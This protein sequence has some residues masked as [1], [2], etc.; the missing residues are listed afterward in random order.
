MEGVG[1]GRRPHCRLSNAS[2][3]LRPNRRDYRRAPCW[4]ARPSTHKPANETQ[5]PI[6]PRPRKCAGAARRRPTAKSRCS[7]GRADWREGHARLPRCRRLQHRTSQNQRRWCPTSRPGSA[8][9]PGDWAIRQAMIPPSPGF[10]PAQ[11]LPASSWHGG[12]LAGVLVALLAGVVS[13]D[14]LDVLMRATC[15]PTRGA[16]W[17]EQ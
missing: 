11:N 5:S 7:R 2:P 9:A 6:V 16:A 3:H 4:G 14:V 12:V 8:C 10:R 13:V 1:F 17:E 15:S